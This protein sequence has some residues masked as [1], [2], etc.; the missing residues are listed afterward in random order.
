M[1]GWGS[2]DGLIVEARTFLSSF[3]LWEVQHVRRGGN[4]VAH[5]LAKFAVSQQVN[6]VWMEVY[7][8]CTSEIVNA[9]QEF[10]DNL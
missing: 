8:N 5:Q 1:M 6:Q 9:E 4:E 10:S 3:Q 2:L 7:P